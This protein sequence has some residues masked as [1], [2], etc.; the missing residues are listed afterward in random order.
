MPDPQKQAE[1]MQEIRAW[2]KE[3]GLKPKNL[4]PTKPTDKPKE[5]EE[6]PKSALDAFSDKVGR[7]KEEAGSKVQAFVDSMRGKKE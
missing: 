2:E 5:T 6:K 4:T 1:V 7:A 3:N